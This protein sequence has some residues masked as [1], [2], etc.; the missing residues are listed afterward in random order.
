MDNKKEFDFN[1][2][3]SGYEKENYTK[4]NSVISDQMI[5]GFINISAG[6]IT[7]ITPKNTFHA[8]DYSNSE[9]IANCAMPS[10]KYLDLTLG[11]SG[12]SYT[13]PADGFL[14]VAKNATVS[15]QRIK[16][17][18]STTQ[19]G[20]SCWSSGNQNVEAFLPVRKGATIVATYN[21]AGT[22][23]YFRFI[24]ANGAA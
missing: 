13:M 20:A 2:Y 23:N 21:A 6:T 3:K 7:S 10:D 15:G 19:M 5:S 9:Y 11:A 8:L 12:T 16:L 4:F 17:Y 24:Y 22:T 14:W 18:D 1:Q